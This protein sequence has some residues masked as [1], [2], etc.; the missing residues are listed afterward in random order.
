LWQNKFGLITKETFRVI[1]SYLKT[2]VE[3]NL[4]PTVSRPVC[5]GVRCPSGTRVQFFFLLEISFRQLRVRYFV[6]PSLTRG[7]VCNLLYNCFW[8][9]FL[10]NNLQKIEFVPHRKHVMSPL[11]RPTNRCLTVRTISSTELH[12]VGR[13]QSCSMFK[14]GGTYV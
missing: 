13:M 10:Q 3:V 1:N 7:R 4:Q 12:S 2:E 5:L 14:A 6:A 8:A 9:L 11:C